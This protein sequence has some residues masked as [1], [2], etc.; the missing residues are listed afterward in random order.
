MGVNLMGEKKYYV[1]Q[2]KKILILE[3]I[4]KEIVLIQ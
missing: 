2:Q 1:I 3:N 4:V